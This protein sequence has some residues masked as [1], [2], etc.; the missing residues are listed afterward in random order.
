LPSKNGGALR[1]P[2]INGQEAA[3]DNSKWFAAY[4]MSRH[5][6]RIAAQCDRIGIEHLLPLYVLQKT[7]KN[8]VRVDV[9]LP[10]FPNYIFARLLPGAHVA[11]LQVPGVLSMVGNAA[12][13]VPILAEDMDALRQLVRCK[14][15]LP[16]ASYAAETAYASTEDHSSGLLDWYLEETTAYAF[17]VTLD[18]IGKSVA[19][20]LD[21]TELETFGPQSLS[22]AKSRS[23]PA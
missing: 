14:P 15:F 18:V 3:G 11:L 7:W 17:I 6:K 23:L 1:I 10:L 13:S 8:R 22:L 19:V 9:Q 21:A 16:H 5:E 12:G 2:S 20:D 4:T